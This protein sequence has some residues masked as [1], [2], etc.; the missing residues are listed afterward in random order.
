MWRPIFSAVGIMLLIM[1]VQFFLVDEAILA[2]SVLGRRGPATATSSLGGTDY[3]LLGETG[4]LASRNFSPPE[5]APYSL[6]SLGTVVL[7]YALG[8]RPRS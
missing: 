7:L 2:D 4:P 1:G 6:M 8:T 3:D 5:W